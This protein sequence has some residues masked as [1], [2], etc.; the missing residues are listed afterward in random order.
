MF[1]RKVSQGNFELVHFNV[2]ELSFQ[3]GEKNFSNGAFEYSTKAS[4]FLTY[5]KVFLGVG[6][7]CVKINSKL[8]LLEGEV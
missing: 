3:V 6:F 5:F 1:K 4:I 2:R 7:R 8:L